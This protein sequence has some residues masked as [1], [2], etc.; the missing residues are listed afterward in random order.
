M[1]P[2]LTE[3]E[4]RV[5]VN[6]K[7]LE[8]ATK[9]QEEKK[10]LQDRAQKLETSRQGVS[11][12]VYN[13][14]KNDYFKKLEDLK[15]RM[16]G[17]KKDLD[18]E[19]VTITEKKIQ[20]EANLKL[21]VE[22]VEEAK[23]RHSLG[24]F[25]TED[26]EKVAQGETEEIKRLE[27]ALKEVRHHLERF[28]GLLETPSQKPAPVPM[29]PPPPPPPTP[30]KIEPKTSPTITEKKA[31]ISESTAKV[32]LEEKKAA[33][34]LVVMENGKVSEKIEVDHNIGI[35]RSPANDV[36]LKEPKVS[37]QHAQIQI[38][39]DNYLLVDL[40]SSN[41]TYVGGNKI[42]EHLLKPNDEI[43]IGKTTMVFKV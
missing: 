5:S 13:R 23:L 8:E 15:N 12:A 28:E 3:K 41:G 35:G 42:T 24:E 11:E 9:I 34:S 1:V 37:R 21:H 22:E 4:L 26:Y 30:P 33:P 17:L 29:K 40:N 31:A 38:D 20:V 32:P 6:E 27:E 16:E 14:V 10:V 7:L 18:Q 43:R 36:V 2:K 39:G 19:L 25:P